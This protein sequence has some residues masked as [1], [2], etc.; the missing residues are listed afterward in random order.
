MLFNRA[1][2]TLQLAND[3]STG[4]SAPV[5]MG[6]PSTLSNSQCTLSAA[7]A[8]VAVNGNNLTVSIPIS[9]AFGFAGVKASFAL[10]YDS[11]LNSGWQ[12]TGS[13]TVPASGPPA[14]LSATPASGTGSY[15]TFA[16]TV[17]DGG[18]P[19]A[20]SVISF[21]LSNGLNGANACWAIYSKA[22][23]SLQLANDAGT[24]LLGPITIGS[25][26]TLSNSQCTIYAATASVSSGGS[27]LTLNV[28]VSFTGTFAG[29]KSAFALVY[30]TGNLNSGWIATGTWTVPGP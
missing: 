7:A 22:A 11:S 26:S 12:N 2:N 29:T 9:F 14:I 3:A 25:G 8:T 4:F 24:G 17:A 18:G 23:N 27:T 15:Q 16:V 1:G 10:A 20:I 19:A 13:W 30:D 6:T 21:L 28:P 5:T